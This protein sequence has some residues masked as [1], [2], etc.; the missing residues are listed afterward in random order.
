M[1]T[2]AVRYT[3]DV[4]EHVEVRLREICLALPEVSETVTRQG[5]PGRAWQVR[6]RKF[7]WE[8]RFSKADLRRLGDAS[9][10]ADPIL[11]LCVEDEGEKQAVLAEGAA[12]FFTIAHLDGYPILL[13]ELSRADPARLRD[14]IEDA[15]LAKAPPDL[16]E[17]LR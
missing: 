4:P 1:A 17:R 2:G 5:T 12:G 16:R 7:A 8:R 10:P 13:V 6:T 9:V 11:A 14:A 15:W 3:D